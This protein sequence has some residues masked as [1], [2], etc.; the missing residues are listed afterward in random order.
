MVPFIRLVLPEPNLG[1]GNIFTYIDTHTG[2]RTRV[3]TMSR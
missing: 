3:F 1:L 2:I